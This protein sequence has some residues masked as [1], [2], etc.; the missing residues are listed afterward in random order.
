LEKTDNL[1]ASEN[2]WTWLKELRAEVIAKAWLQRA[3]K[4]RNKKLSY[5]EGC[6]I[7]LLEN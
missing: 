5:L 4:Y 7:S 2:W 6:L 1:R 3:E